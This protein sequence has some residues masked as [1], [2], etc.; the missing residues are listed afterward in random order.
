[1]DQEER[2]HNESLLQIYTGHLR[3]LVFRVRST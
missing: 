2:A 1:M 3:Q